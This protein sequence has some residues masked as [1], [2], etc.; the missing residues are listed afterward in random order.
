MAKID[1]VFEPQNQLTLFV[2]KGDIFADD[3]I[4]AFSYHYV[5]N[6]TRFVIWDLKQ[7]SI[8][9]I[10]EA[11]FQRIAQ[12]ALAVAKYRAGGKTCYIGD[13][14]IN[15][16]LSRMYTQIAEMAQM[17]VQYGVERSMEGARNWLLKN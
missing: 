1:V 3:I 9:G 14:N 5:H 13:K 4:D 2:C 6:P 8:A 11:D 17:P 12:A 15:Y 16:G 7:G 10:N